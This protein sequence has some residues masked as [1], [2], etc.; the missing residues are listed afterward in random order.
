MTLGNGLDWEGMSSDENTMREQESQIETLKG[1]ILQCQRHGTSMQQAGHAMMLERD[2]AV[3]LLRRLRH[4]FGVPR[5]RICG[6]DLGCQ[7]SEGTWA[8][9]GY[10][11]ENDVRVGWKEGRSLVDQHYTDSQVGRNPGDVHEWVDTLL[12]PFLD[13]QGPRLENETDA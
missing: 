10:L 6:E 2:T 4:A 1:Q 13:K 9:T 12:D 7:N 5:C 3:A 8:C 11:W